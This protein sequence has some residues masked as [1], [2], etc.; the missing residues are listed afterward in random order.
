MAKTRTDKRGNRYVSFEEDLSERMRDPAFREGYAERRYIHEIA[1]AI[2]AMR[3]SAGLSQADLAAMIG[4]KQPAIARL[5]TSQ[6]RRPQWQT[7]D[8][9]A[10]ALGRQLEL[11]LGAVDD[12]TPLVKVRGL[13]LDDARP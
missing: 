7:L 12:K 5:E 6:F 11:A 2:R 10:R 9:I 13:K 8:R 3:E 1:R 4:T